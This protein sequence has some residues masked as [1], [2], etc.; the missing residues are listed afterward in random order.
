MAE[1]NVTLIDV[2]WGDSIF[3]E[4]IDEN[5]E[6]HFALIDS[7]DKEFERSAEIF[8]KKYLRREGIKYK[9][10]K[11]NFEFVMISHWHE[12]HVSG[13]KRIIRNFGTRRLYYPKT[14]NSALMNSMT[15][16]ADSEAYKVRNKWSMSHQSIHSNKIMQP[17]GDVQMNVLWPTRTHV[18]PDE[19]NNSIVL[20]MTLD[21]VKYLLTG[22]AERVVWDNITNLIPKDTKFFKVPHHG[23]KNGTFVGRTTP[24]LDRT[25]RLVSLGVSGHIGRFTLPHP[26]V[27]K[28]F[29]NR[30]R[31]Y[32][33]T[34][35]DYHLTFNTKGN[36]RKKVD[37]KYSRIE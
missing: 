18:D 26:D 23:S 25:N 10:N 8:L 15:S 28:L 36:N 34:D 13:L 6:P 35:Y 22:D 4:H 30:P 7:N 12:D 14:Q 2:G 33:R 31:D 17:F 37:V 9:D 21:N 3:I 11:P 29:Q 32:Y 5:D 16:F 20:Q 27:I 24:W 1:L 19:N